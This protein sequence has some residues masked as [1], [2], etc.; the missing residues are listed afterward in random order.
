MTEK[1]ENY[2]KTYNLYRKLVFKNPIV[3][4]ML[5]VKVINTFFI[6]IFKKDLFLIL[7]RNNEENTQ[8]TR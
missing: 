8:K 6:H 2:F 5:V 7:K 4:N 1:A 3:R